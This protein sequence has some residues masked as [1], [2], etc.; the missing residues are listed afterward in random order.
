ML[1][2]SITSVLAVCCYTEQSE[3]RSYGTTQVAIILPAEAKHNSIN[4]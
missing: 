3:R 1:K 2:G 4:N